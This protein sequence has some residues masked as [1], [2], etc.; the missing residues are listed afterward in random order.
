MAY[1]K[2]YGPLL[3]QERVDLGFAMLGYLTANAWYKKKRELREFLP[4]WMKPRKPKVI[5][6][7]G[8]LLRAA[9]EAWAN[10]MR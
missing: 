4:S 9:L 2:L 5:D 6:K 7:D 8:S 3:V 1:E 10:E